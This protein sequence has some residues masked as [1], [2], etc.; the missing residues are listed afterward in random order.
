MKV[1]TSETDRLTVRGLYESVREMVITWK[2]GLVCN[3]PPVFVNLDNA[4]RERCKFIPFTSTFTDHAPKTLAEQFR[5]QRFRADRNLNA[6]RMSAYARVLMD[7][8]FTTY[9]Q[10]NMQSPTYVLRVPRRIHM[11]ADV[12]LQ[13]VFDFQMWVQGFFLPASTFDGMPIHRTLHSHLRTAMERILAASQAWESLHPRWRN[14]PWNLL[15]RRLKNA[16]HIVGSPGWVRCQ[17]VYL[18]RLQYIHISGNNLTCPPD[19]VFRLPLNQYDHQI[20]LVDQHTVLAEYNRHRRRSRSVANTTLN[21]RNTMF[22]RQP[23]GPHPNDGRR[24][25]GDQTRRRFRPDRDDR[26]HA[27][28]NRRKHGDHGRRRGPGG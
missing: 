9:V 18:H 27:R 25:S 1:M 26:P 28:P 24:D 20:T 8:F 11:E 12:Y 6:E 23:V 13:E 21:P 15:P 17:S 10:R 2:L 3:W 22:S 16:V 4:T 14:V 5:S 7:M 19:S